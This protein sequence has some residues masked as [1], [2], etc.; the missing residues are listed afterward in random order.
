MSNYWSR[1]K[2]YWLV[3][4]KKLRGSPNSIAIGFACGVGVSFT[5]FVGA[6]LVLAMFFAWCLRGNI[7]AAAL[8]TAFGNPWTFPF[9][10]LS[11]LYTGKK[12]LGEGFDGI[13]DVDFKSLFSKAFEALIN[14][15]FEDF[16]FDIWPIFYPMIIGAVPYMIIFG[17]LT[18]LL[19]KNVLVRSKH[20]LKSEI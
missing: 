5:P 2:K 12:L 7:I 9:I 10:W 8:G 15:D 18:Y 19:V 14:F 17:M 11:V 13:V 3:R 6:H 20:A 16:L 4:L 1:Q